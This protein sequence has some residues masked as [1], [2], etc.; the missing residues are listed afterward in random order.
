M[1]DAAAA[2][3]GAVPLKERTA[4]DV[5]ANLDGQE[6]EVVEQFVK[7]LDY[8]KTE[9]IGLS[10][11]AG[12]TGISSGSLSPCFNG[13]YN[14]DYGAVAQRIASFFW[15]LDQKALYGGLRQFRETALAKALWNVFEKVRII[16]RIQ[17]IEGP[18][19]VG[20]S[21]AADEYTTRN[22]HGRT[23]MVQLPG[24]TRDG[25]CQEFIWNLADK[26]NIARTAKLREKRAR[27]REALEACDLLIID[28]VHVMATWGDRSVAEF[29]DYLRTD[30]FNNGERGI[31]L[32][33]TNCSMMG[34]LQ[35]FRLRARYNL[36]QLLGRM[37][38]EVVRIDPVDDVSAED[39]GLL[40]ERYY[41]PS[42]ACLAKLHEVATRPQL[43]HL[44]L[45]LDVMNE[46]WTRAKSRKRQLDDAMV[47]ATLESILKELAQRK[48]LYEAR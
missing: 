5:R 43:G 13:T 2:K 33:A 6:P 23:I 30:L 7:L 39:V 10:T 48:S 38:N 17:L 29:L 40:V 22:N 26:L 3:Q 42:A 12:Q 32:V 9:N 24:G 1:E 47:L 18:D 27:I 15:R 37:R 16:R 34:F 28:E 25:G 11:L 31:V 20:K 44:G 41:K 4:E 14:G 36:G 46:A 45:I 35:E 21:R 8:A 19:Q